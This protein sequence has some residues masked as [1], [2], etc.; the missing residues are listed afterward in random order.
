[1][2]MRPCAKHFMCIIFLKFLQQDLRQVLLLYPSYRYDKGSEDLTNCFTSIYLISEKNVKLLIPEVCFLKKKMLIWGYVFID[3]FRD[4][5]KH[6]LVASC[7]CPDQG[8][9]R[10]Q[11]CNL[12]RFVPWPWIKP[13]TFWCM[14]WHSNQ[15]GH[16][17]RARACTLKHYTVTFV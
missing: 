12:G 13:T 16:P 15:L 3:F 11:T 17:A 4:L 7:R 6:L 14:G 5:E 8:L 2:Y 10:D 9:T 1:M